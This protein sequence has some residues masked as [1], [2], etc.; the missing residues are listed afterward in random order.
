MSPL[1]VDALVVVL[2]A[3]APVVIERLRGLVH[4]GGDLGFMFIPHYAWW[5]SRPRW[6]GGWN[7]WIFG[8]F[9]SNADPLV[10]HVHPLGLL[11]AIVPP[12]DAAALEGVAAPA[13][14]G[15]GMLLYLRRVGCGRTGSVVGALAFACGGYVHAHAMHPEK[16]R[17]VLAI[18]WALAAIEAL[19][20]RRLVA[21][22][23]TAVAVIVAGG[24]P[25]TMVF[26]LALVAAYGF[27]FKPD[28]RARVFAGLV[29]GV[30]IPAVTWMPALEL[31]A[32]SHHVHTLITGV[33][34]LTA[35]CAHTL[36][37]PFGCGGGSGPF[38]GLAFEQFPGCGIVDCTG[39][40]GM[41]VWLLVLAGLPSLLSSGRG[42]FWIAVGL[43]GLLLSTDIVERLLPIPGVRAP[44]R[45]LLWWSFASAVA[46]ASVAGADG[47][48][49]GRARWVAA[50]VLVVVVAWASTRGAVAWRASLGSFAVLA[51]TVV[52]VSRPVHWALVAV[53]VADLGV[54]GSELHVGVPPTFADPATDALRRAA[55]ALR[56][57][58]APAG[59]AIAIP[60]LHD[61]MW[62][63]VERVPIL[64]G[65]NVLVP[66]AFSRLLAGDV[67]SPLGYDFGL[68]QDPALLDSKSHVLDLL[69]ARVA[70]VTA[71]VARD[72]AWAAKLAESRWR[73]AGEWAQWR[74]YTNARA[75]PV[76]WL[77]HRVREVRD[78]AEAL[79]IVR[80]ESGRF[81]PAVEAI[82]GRPFAV[83]PA[84]G[85]ETVAVVTNDDDRLV[86][87]ARAS[88][89][90]LLV[91]S[92]LAYPGW[93]ATVDGRA[94]IVRTVNAGFR[95]V[96]LAAGEHEVVLRYRPRI[97][98]IGLALG[99]VGV[100]FVVR[101]AV[102]RRRDAHM[103]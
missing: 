94:V 74:L 58:D 40:P 47:T 25:Q 7:P 90:S 41:L 44:S 62:A 51:A 57:A 75:R 9:P 68:V 6:L 66:A 11:W 14:A 92:E 100:L 27:V 4:A 60:A 35:A 81:D 19:D 55:S 99:I 28:A 98:L 20:D 2:A 64:Q 16:L 82:A 49:R 79:R 72:P 91:T 88:A 43:A 77:V 36:V 38:Y 13:L 83:S 87:R 84:T 54:F 103:A 12:L 59:R 69:R 42:R 86:L 37:V 48:W 93:T 29:V 21:G 46:A 1:V 3:S 8:G 97:G 78:D 39:Y 65:W 30:A 85:A 10:G 95:A 17:S 67:A 63:Q 22:L 56:D 101:C 31:V 53:L 73:A 89:P 33:D 96:E 18:P 71:S 80:G 23:G 102:P 70:V 32:R 5:W 76:A 45:A 15:L 52:A 61:A 50:L 26:S 34:H 24:H